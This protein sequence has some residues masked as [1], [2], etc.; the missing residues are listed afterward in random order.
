VHSSNGVQLRQR[1]DA[2]AL[3]AVVA[4]L[5][6][7]TS[8]DDRDE[9]AVQVE[10][11][12]VLVGEVDGGKALIALVHTS[13]GVTV[14]TCGF[15]DQL[16][17]HTGW[18]NGVPR[19]ESGVRVIP[20]VTNSDGLAVTGRIAGDKASGTLTLA[21]GQEVK[22]SAERASNNG[23]G[24]YAAE[25]AASLSG[26][27]V[28][29][30][31]RMV[32]SSTLRLSTTTTLDGG[33][34]TSPTTTTLARPTTTT[35]LQ[36][37]TSTKLTKTVPILVPTTRPAGRPV[38][39]NIP[40]VPEKPRLTTVTPITKPRTVTRT[41]AAIVFLVHGM[42]DSTGTPGSGEAFDATAC[43][44]PGNTPFYSRCEWGP[45][46]LPGLFGGDEGAG[47]VNLAGDD[48]TGNRY[49]TSAADPDFPQIDETLRLAQ[50][51]NGCAVD[52]TLEEDVDDANAAHFI[53][54]PGDGSLDGRFPV[55]PR[56]SVFTTYRDSTRGIVESGRRIT[57][58]AYAAARWWE[59]TYKE[60]PQIIFVTQSFGGLATRFLLSNPTD[61]SLAA[62]N[63][64]R[65][66]LCPE[67]HARMDY[68]RNRTTYA[69]TLATPHEGSFLSE[70]G[71]PAKEFL[72][73]ALTDID[74][75]LADNGLARMSQSVDNIASLALANPPNIIET[76]RLEIANLLALLDTP[77][78][79]DMKLAN[80]VRWNTGP[81][82]PDRARRTAAS[83]LVGAANELI[84][85]YATLARSPGSTAFDSPLISE[86]FEVYDAERP[87]MQ[88]WIYGTSIDSQ[89]LVLTFSEVRWGALDGPLAGHAAVLDRRGRIFD[90]SDSTAAAEAF[91]E[92]AA[93]NILGKP[94]AYFEGAFGAGVD[95]VLSY[96]D[97][98]EVEAFFPTAMT[99]LYTEHVW[100]IDLTGSVDVPMIAFRCGANEIVLDYEPLV[101]ALLVAHGRTPA[102]LDA[103]G[104]GDLVAVLS[105]AQIAVQDGVALA[106]E[107]MDWFKGK[108]A[109][110][111]SIEGD[112]EIPV[113]AED[114]VTDFFSLANIA[115][116][117]VVG[118]TGPVPAPE[119]VETLGVNR[120]G[121]QDNDGAVHAAS[122]LG[123]QLGREPFFFEHDRGGSWYRLADNPRTERYNHGLQYQNDV[124]LFV[125]ERFFAAGVGPVPQVDG[126]STWT[127]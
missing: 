55:P 81:I 13:K 76:A 119:W 8:S 18:F 30:D 113:D 123:F 54:A 95:G 75:G 110:L 124:G 15:D 23:A 89:F 35:S 126:D 84:P 21:S 19:T 98:A 41:G 121:E 94:A 79:R 57:R 5:A 85:I 107:T 105:A 62:L 12:E 88:G 77:A 10:Q 51:A 72:R 42:S 86:G 2:A 68:L 60:T 99:P 63:P 115:N 31:E 25:D 66:L 92:Q 90:L 74:A 102:A 28:A 48:M 9:D 29:E 34:V 24:L 100:I 120:D 93:E 14:Y 125:Q 56:L 108:V 6:G 49:I 20:K 112:C 4:L 7:C 80:M 59:E 101:R 114:V 36:L 106:E 83:P 91:V 39:V 16:E 43:T 61:E 70:V 38:K 33:T 111:D 11:G 118:T 32:G 117:R 71:E 104:S 69:L 64:D 103:I 50:R 1:Q 40:I 45:D 67:D 122:A 127:Q 73:D 46:F 44:G 47:L 26:L 53:A 58:Q 109:E 17:T 87:K 78:L 116:W 65:I 3:V 97:D 96:L 82:A 27:I 52:P 37:S 22:W